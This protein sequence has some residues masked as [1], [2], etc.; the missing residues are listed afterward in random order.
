MGGKLAPPN[1][2]LLLLFFFGGGGAFFG[3]KENIIF[4]FSIVNNDI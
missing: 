4:R 2:F 3:L 1:F